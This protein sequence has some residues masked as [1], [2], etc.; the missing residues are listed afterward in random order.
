[1]VCGVVMRRL[2]RRPAAWVFGVATILLTT[3][4]VVGPDVL[5]APGPSGATTAPLGRG[6]R[7]VSSADGLSVTTG[8]CVPGWTART[9]GPVVFRIDDGSDKP[10]EVY[11]F[12]PYS[13][14]TVAH[15]ALHPGA[16]TTLSLRLK[17][18]RYQ[19]SCALRGQPDRSSSIATVRPVT[20]NG[21][22]GPM[23]MVPV[24]SQQVAGAIGSYRAYV[25]SELSLETSQVALLQAAIAGGQLAAARTA[26]LT[27]H[28]TWHRIGGAYDA[29]GNLGLSIDGT[30]D[31][32][33]DGVFSPQ[34]TGF[35][36]VEMDLW[37][38]NDLS[39]AA[40][41]SATL[42]VDV[43]ELA[44]QFPSESIPA[45]ELPLR[46]HEI[47][48][49]ALRDELSG[50]DDYGSGT[51]MASVEAD[52]DGTRELLTLLT[53]LLRPRAPDLVS[54]VTTELDALD[55]ALAATQSDG[56]WVA[57]TQV[58]L[59]QREQVDGAIGNALETLDLVP[60]L[61]HVVGST[62]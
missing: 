56:Q 49:D 61:L 7:L 53:P 4:L 36:K 37:Q 11:L 8:H 6:V 45:T 33:Q 12:N 60:E 14:V 1:M 43:K 41:D 62:T 55:T 34:F 27:A 17:V 48:E 3:A 50:D 22:A 30:A 44:V 38:T 10:G 9:A 2:Y 19:W 58:P 51:D 15:G 52:V 5:S 18:G 57:V 40:T 42:L 29:F 25:T 28:L 32:L 23:V 47:L 31:R 13:G 21:P 35:H 26:W 16:V 20:I 39:T 54:T 46:T 24:T 59:A